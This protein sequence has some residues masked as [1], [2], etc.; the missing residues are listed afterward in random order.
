[1]RKYLWLSIIMLGLLFSLIGCSLPTTPAPKPTCDT[2]S[3]QQV[4]LVDPPMWSIVGSLNPTLSWT[5]PDPACDPEG[6]A[7]RLSTGPLFEDDLGGG[8]GNPST[9]WGP[10]APLEP[11]KEYRWKVAPINGETLG[12][13]RG[14]SYF[15]TGPLRDT[16]ALIAP[17]LM[18][19]PDGGTFDE[20]YDSLIWDY[21]DDCIPEGYRVDLSTDPT[22]ADTS[23][24]GGTGNPSTRWGPGTELVECEV[25]YWRVAPINYTTLGPFSET[26]SFV[27]DSTGECDLP[28]FIPPSGL[29]P[30]PTLEP[31]IPVEPIEPI[32]VDCS[33]LEISACIAN[34]QCTWVPGVVTGQGKCV[35]N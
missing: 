15:F 11:G 14:Y 28:G 5:Y 23:L 30:R 34:P 7:I 16:A 9:S 2:A 20:A 29:R 1:M 8:T 25:Y 33:K 31:L 17:V 4:T 27:K 35:D 32:A 13:W 26:W 22:F 18:H 10:G 3:L 24:S 19:P 6:Y 21:P 12:P